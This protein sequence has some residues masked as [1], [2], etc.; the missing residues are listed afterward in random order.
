MTNSRDTY[1]T[2][3]EQSQGG[4]DETTA[5]TSTSPAPE[6]SSDGSTVS[7]SI[8]M[9]KSTLAILLASV[10]LVA[11]SWTSLPLTTA[12]AAAAGEKKSIVHSAAMGSG[13]GSGT[14]ADA[15]RPCTLNECVA[16]GCNNEIA[17]Y[18][19]ELHN[20][21]PH[22]GCSSY[23]WTKLSCDDQCDLSNCD[24]LVIPSSADSCAGKECGEVF[25]KAG[26]SCGSSAPYQC[27]RGSANWGCT[28]D[29]LGWTFKTSDATCS[30]CCD[31]T[32]C[33]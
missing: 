7:V 12:A 13:S 15:V 1:S 8:T 17:P 14:V 24:S 27:M 18:V 11:F 32:T 28:E 2:I 25:C 16:A 21:G 31:T 4:P 3:E 19:C 29:P 5:F 23:P 9:K 6:S 22:G 20:G 10:L 30:E 33:K 26:Q